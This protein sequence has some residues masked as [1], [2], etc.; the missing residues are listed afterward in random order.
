MMMSKNLQVFALM[1]LSFFLWISKANGQQLDFLNAV[2]FGDGAG[3]NDEVLHI[4]HYSNGDILTVGQFRGRI[5]FDPNP[6]AFTMFFNQSNSGGK[7]LARYTATGIL[8]WAKAIVNNRSLNFYDLTL[9]AQEN[10]LMTGSFLGTLD[11]PGGTQADQLVGFSANNANGFIAKLTPT[12]ELI[13]TKMFSGTGVDTGMRIKLNGLGEA[14]ITGQFMHTV[15]FAPN[16]PTKT[17]VSAGSQDIFIAAYNAGNGQLNW[18]TSIPGVGSDI[19][20][21]LEIDAQNNIYVSGDFT[22]TITFPTN[23]PSP[24]V[25]TG[26]NDVFLAKFNPTGT[27]QWARKIGGTSTDLGA[28]LDLSGDSLLLVSGSYRLNIQFDHGGSTPNFTSS[29]SNA[30]IFVAAYDTSGAYQWNVRFGSSGTDR[31]FQTTLDDSARVWLAGYVVQPTDIDPGPSTIMTGNNTTANPYLTSYNLSDGSY[32]KHFETAVTGFA[33]FQA[34]SSGANGQLV[35]GGYFRDSITLNPNSGGHLQLNNFGSNTS[36]SFWSVYQQQAD[37]GWSTTERRGGDDAVKRMVHDVHGNLFVG[38]TF[39]GMADF[40]IYGNTPFLL[41]SYGDQDA[42]VASYRPDGSLRWARHFGG[43]GNDELAGMAIDG[44]GNVYLGGHFVQNFYMPMASGGFDTLIETPTGILPDR[45]DIFMIKLDST[46]QFQWGHQLGGTNND[47]L[48]DLHVSPNGDIA[49]TGS[50]WANLA[51]DPLL[52]G[53]GTYSANNS[54]GYV[55]RYNTNGQF[56]WANIINGSSSQAGFGI[57]ID[58]AMN[59][60]V[61]GSYRGT[62]NFDPGPGSASMTS[63]FNSDDVFIAKYNSNGILQWVNGYGHS[64]FETGFGVTTDDQGQ[65]FMTGSF[66]NSVDFNPNGP[67]QLLTSNGDLDIFVLSLTPTGQFRWVAPF[68]GAGRDVPTEIKL[69]N[70]MLFSVGSF[71]DTIDF[72]HGTGSLLGISNGADDG[73][74]HIVDTAGNFVNAAAMGSGSID[75]ANAVSFRLGRT[76]VG[77]NHGAS[78]DANPGV[79]ENILERKGGQDAF[80]ITYG[81]AGPCD[82][83]KQTIQIAACGS[84]EFGGQVYQTTGI[85]VKT[86]LGPNGCDSIVTL[87]LT[88][89]PEFTTTDSVQACGSY[90]WAGQVL[91]QSGTY[92]DSLNTVL[93]CDSTRMLHLIIWPETVDTISEISC[94]QFF[95]PVNNQTYTQSGFFHDTLV[96]TNGCDSILI[97]HLTLFQTHRD[98]TSQ[99]SCQQFFWPV[100]NQ[101]YFQSGWYSDT[102][103]TA[104]GCDLIRFLDLTISPSY[105]DST[106][107]TACA[108]FVWPANNQTYNQSGQYTTQLTSAAG[109][110][111]SI[112]IDLT[113][114][115]VDTQIQLQGLTLTASATNATFQWLDCAANFTMIAGAVGQSYLVAT[116]GQYAV[117]VTQQG[118][119]DTS[120]CISIQNV[121]LFQITNYDKF[122]LWPNPAK[123][124]VQVALPH[125]CE[126]LQLFDVYGRL[127]MQEEVWGLSEIQW[128]LNLPKGTYHVMALLRNGTSKTRM[129]V[130]Q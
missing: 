78:F 52:M 33:S 10:I 81:I 57:H 66:S 99:N 12:G 76:W 15:E 71:R 8:V 97:L 100:T 44:S 25:T 20:R 74:V 9:D 67:S 51:L 70:G 109:C 40:N 88:I 91:M 96:S 92:S 101:T 53:T 55:A 18:V 42:Y 98:T 7:Y 62:V 69:H 24:V 21:G 4:L 23:P 37:T 46:G 38:G 47:F 130:I 75:A 84:Y 94:D 36:L 108:P 116:N 80:I 54:A 41:T 50:F 83:T 120:Q 35:A 117:A 72:D 28:W 1:G 26:G 87:D 107:L 59:V 106:S 77:G 127:L 17:R 16:D 102:S 60:L 129:L 13:W 114:I 126:F 29:N 11:F 85:Y 58:N 93:G 22:A 128:T 31:I 79:A 118:C 103:Q 30:D 90:S 121:G 45:T 73:Y 123:T 119:T 39:A 122:V 48:R 5:D 63:S 2:N 95:W 56:L 105:S 104:L 43:L 113:I 27:L 111:S 68:G 86:F 125:G 14:V 89:N 61:T 112:T 34:L 110:D 49:I 82:T 64:L 65:V 115:Q 19:A 32:S 6:N 3:L 124:T